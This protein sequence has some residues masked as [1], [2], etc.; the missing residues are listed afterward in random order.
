MT[1]RYE[2]L[3]EVESPINARQLRPLDPRCERVQ[4]CKPLTD[5][6]F[7]KLAKF[8][9]RYPKVC[10]R[11]Y[12]PNYSRYDLSFLRYFPFLRHFAVDVYELKDFDALGH[13]GPQLETLGLG[14]TKS[15]STSLEILKRFPKLKSLHLEGQMKGIEVVSS[16]LQLKTLAMTSIT[17]PDLSLL[18]NLASLQ[19]LALSLGG[20]KD[21]DALRRLKKL[22][23]LTLRQVRGLEDLGAVAAVRS[24]QY[25]DLGGLKNVAALPSFAR[26][27]SLR[28]V[29][30]Q[31]MKGLT[32]LA[33]V[34]KAP[35]LEELSVLK[36]PQLSQKHFQP[37]VGHKNL[38]RLSVGVG[39][40]KRNEAI[41]DMLGIRKE[42]SDEFKFRRS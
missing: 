10:L 8:M 3:R 34:A 32:D 14:K 18:K 41:Q 27:K 1:A 19:T 38:S 37:F 33:P 16:L 25:L 11:V 6:D 42:V 40:L 2:Y 36:M 13:L 15:R 20:T 24:L 7:R 23:Y 9:K 30:L 31:T 28:R 12:T 26:L 21:L 29:D 17:L 4:F 35:A 5:A 22:G 39:S